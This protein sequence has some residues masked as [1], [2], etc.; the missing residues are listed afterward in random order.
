M[1]W[2]DWS[3]MTDKQRLE[4]IHMRPAWHLS[5]FRRFEFYVKKDGH[6][7]RRRGGGSHQLSERGSKEILRG[8]AGEDVRSKGDNREWKPGVTF[9]FDK[10][11][12]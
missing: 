7:S 1:A 6:V 2:V 9:H 4:A 5:D 11:V 10:T 8:I 3:K 12:D